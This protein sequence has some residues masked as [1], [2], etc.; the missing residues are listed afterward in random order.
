MNTILKLT[1]AVVLAVVITFKDGLAQSSEPWLST[2]REDSLGEIGKK[3][4]AGIV[5]PPIVSVYKARSFGEVDKMIMMQ[6]IDA[7]RLL[8]KKVEM[9]FAA[10][11]P[12]NV[13]QLEGEVSLLLALSLKAR[14]AG[15]YTN[16]LVSDSL[17]RLIIYRLSNWIYL[18]PQDVAVCKKSLSLIPVMDESYSNLL[19]LFSDDDKGLSGQR[20]DFNKIDA[21]D[22][23]FDSLEA[24]GITYGQVSDAFISNEKSMNR[25]LDDPSALLLVMKLCETAAL[26][27]IHLAGLI[28]FFEKGGAI[29]DLDPS[30]VTAFNKVMG[31]ELDTYH[32]TPFGIDYLSVN[33]LLFLIKLREDPAVGAAFLKD[34]FQ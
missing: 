5:W 12:S 22:R 13:Q 33:H 4:E 17:N 3:V 20:L 7:S 24:V 8:L 28:R 16:Y 32:Y 1:L 25:L 31:D 2:I 34:A 21:K 9:E 14:A 19:R 10:K 27:K 29:S 23:I 6:R 30:N 15:G 11:E 18:H 26:K